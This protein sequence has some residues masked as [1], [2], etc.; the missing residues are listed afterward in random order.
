MEN[1]NEEPEYEDE[2]EDEDEEYYE[3]DYIYKDKWRY[4]FYSTLAFLIISSPYTYMLVNKLLGEFVKVSSANGC[5]TM[6]GLL[7]HAVVFALIIRSM[8]EL[9]I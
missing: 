9:D 5:P 8:M 7:I 3:D 6:M 4:S 1:N 2:D